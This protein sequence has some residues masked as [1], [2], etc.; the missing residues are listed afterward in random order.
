[1]LNEIKTTSDGWRGVIGK[2]FTK[3]N[4][5]CFIYGFLKYAE[6]SIDLSKGLVIGY[7]TRK[8]SEE[9]AEE[10]A[11][12][13]ANKGYQVILTKTPTPSPVT[14]AYMIENKLSAAI[15]ITASHYPS[16]F[17]GIK[18]RLSGGRP[19]TYDE[20]VKILE[21]SSTKQQKILCKCDTMDR[22]NIE[23]LN[24]KKWYS[25]LML[26]KFPDLLKRLELQRNSNKRLIIVDVMH[27][28]TSN[29]LSEI[30][31]KFG[32]RVVEI[33]DTKDPTFGGSRPDPIE[34][35]CKY[36][37]KKVKEQNAVIGVAFDGDGDRVCFID[38]KYGY[39]GPCPMSFL[40]VLSSTLFYGKL[41]P[42]NNCIIK[43]Y[44]VTYRVNQIAKH[45]GLS[46]F[47]VPVGFRNLYFDSVNKKAITGVGD[48]TSAIFPMNSY[49]K[50]GIFTS[51]Y[52]L[53][54]LSNGSLGDIINSL[55]GKYGKLCFHKNNIKYED[56]GV[57]KKIFKD[58]EEV[59]DEKGTFKPMSIIKV[60]NNMKIYW[61]DG[62]ILIRIAGT[63]NFIRIYGEAGEQKVLN[64]RL[65]KVYSI[66]GK[67]LKVNYSKYTELN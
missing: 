50:D 1:M 65:K 16:Q 4:L 25:H 14:I 11:N 20:F 33:R 27:G 37:M 23:I 48:D 26:S 29:I 15:I 12:L 31:G 35:N 18:L 61:E 34:P 55:N 9:Y 5:I 10:I 59:I 49:N 41:M 47:E 56:I 53:Q 40:I 22:G 57:I 38:P 28:T 67:Y 63:E 36:L 24:L 2:S 42:S 54:L 62:W 43:T 51:L 58:I 17:N 39:I 6:S 13:I 60:K 7:D 30:L 64:K 8:F 32:W 66:I 45:Y 21:L 46:V 3:N 44:P 19:P 52:V